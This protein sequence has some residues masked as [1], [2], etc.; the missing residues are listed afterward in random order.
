MSDPNAK[1]VT[2]SPANRKVKALYRDLK[3]AV[4]YVPVDTLKAYKRALRTHSPA[5]IE[6]LEASIQAFGFVQ[7][8]LVDAEGEIVGGHGIF[9]AARKAGYRSVPV[10]RLSHLS[11]AEKRTLRIAL[12]RLAEKS[13]WNQEL[14]ALEFKELLEFDLT[15]DLNFDL[16][17]TGFASPEIDQ[18]IE[19]EANASDTDPDDLA[20]DI[21]LTQ[22][23]VSRLGDLWLLGE[24]R[25]ICGDARQEATYAKLLG[26]ERAAMGI[27]DA[28]YNV[29]IQGHVSKSGRHNE[30]VMGV[31]EWTTD[32]FTAFL[33][34]FLQHATA[35]SRPGAV[36]W[37][38]M[39]W[40]HMGEMLTAGRSVGLELKNLAVWNKGVG[41]LGSMLQ[42]QHELVFMF[43]D[44][45]GPLINNV[46]FGK[47]GRTKSNVWDFPG[48][49][50]L[51]KELKLHP[52]P[53]PV[54]LVAD[55]IRDVSHRNDIV[56]DCF[57]GSGTTLIAC[58]KVGR[59]G[60]AVELD[61]HY[62]DVAITRW[63]Q[64]SGGKVLH[65]A[66]GLSFAEI[67]E[68]RQASTEPQQPDTPISSEFAS[69]VRVRH[70]SARVA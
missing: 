9:E 29:A 18:L 35:F 1:S 28:P 45:H 15:L 38:F 24:H 23:P 8:I 57:S 60:Y 61:P 55:A 56:L 21:D 5:H 53:K 12:N 41:A 11:E 26:G 37:A 68:M 64:W 20:P 2:S 62:V 27:H 25:L 65:A 46:Q 44:P 51:R 52:T 33:A 59:R 63:E 70:R 69:P 7:P 47:Y 32:E 49:A 39:D 30:F 14:L 34:R 10:L 19:S 6:Q 67:A 16:A 48:A 40:R 43:R 36:Q 58:A 22:P 17:I 31:G 42:V 3:L 66:T 50:G 13:G 54:A 4:E